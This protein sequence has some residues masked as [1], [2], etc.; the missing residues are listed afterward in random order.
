M[1]LPADQGKYGNAEGKQSQ[2]DAWKRQAKRLESKQKKEQDQTPGGNRIG[3]S[4]FHSPLENNRD[5]AS[6]LLK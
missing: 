6:L 5:S 2:D 1:F 4:H 3:H